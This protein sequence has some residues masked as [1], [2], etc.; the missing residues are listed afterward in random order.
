[1]GNN[2]RSY[3]EPGTE[4]DGIQGGLGLLYEHLFVSD[5]GYSGQTCMLLLHFTPQFKV[6]PEIL[7]QQF[8]INMLFM[9]F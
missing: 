9:E 7:H 6:F 4:W 5:N 8:Q 3:T 2:S 1:M